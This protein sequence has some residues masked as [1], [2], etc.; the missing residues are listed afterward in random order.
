MFSSSFILNFVAKVVKRALRNTFPYRK[1]W[2]NNTDLLLANCWS[3]VPLRL[4]FHPGLSRVE[5]WYDAVSVYL[6][7]RVSRVLETDSSIWRQVLLLVPGMVPSVDY[8]SFKEEVKVERFFFGFCCFNQWNEN[9][10]L[11]FKRNIRKMMLTRRKQNINWQWDAQA[12]APY[13]QQYM[14]S[15]PRQL[16]TCT[17]ALNRINIVTASGA[18]NRPST[19]HPTA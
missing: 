11:P 14:H 17:A 1:K 4:P 9:T 18:R 8:W 3:I 2:P 15:L 7:R 16:I 10:W 12:L 13:Y 19:L 6:G 5:A